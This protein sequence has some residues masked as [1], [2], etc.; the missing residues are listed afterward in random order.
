MGLTIFH[1]I[2]PIFRLS[3]WNIP[4]DIIMDI[5][6]IQSNVWGILCGILLVPRNIV[7]DLNNVIII[8]GDMKSFLFQICGYRMNM[9]AF[10]SHSIKHVYG[11]WSLHQ[12]PI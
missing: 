2:F 5:S 1:T 4:W 9:C 6:Y 7:L 12:R 11:E 8:L 10:I 3:M